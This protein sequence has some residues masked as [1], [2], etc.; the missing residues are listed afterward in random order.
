MEKRVAFR[1][2]FHQQQPNPI[3]LI[4]AKKAASDDSPPVKLGYGVYGILRKKIATE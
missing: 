3:C 2:T 1:P 4:P